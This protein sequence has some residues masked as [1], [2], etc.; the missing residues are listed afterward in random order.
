M[1][2][3]QPPTSHE[4]DLET[5]GGWSGDT[6]GKVEDMEITKL[7]RSTAHRIMS[8]AVAAL[9]LAF[10]RLARRRERQL[11]LRLEGACASK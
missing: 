4:G 2:R 7:T 1:S 9:A 8:P 3:D 11:R 10:L 5:P 6:Q